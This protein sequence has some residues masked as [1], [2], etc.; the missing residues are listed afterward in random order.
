MNAYYFKFL[1]QQKYQSP[2]FQT[3]QINHIF[4]IKSYLQKYG[5]Y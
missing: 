4:Y 5:F 2:P 1:T 3:F